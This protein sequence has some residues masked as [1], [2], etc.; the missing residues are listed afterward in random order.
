MPVALANFVHFISLLRL[1]VLRNHTAE[2]TEPERTAELHIFLIGH[3]VDNG[4]TILDKLGGMRAFQPEYMAGK[5]D[6]GNL[7]SKANTEIGNALGARIFR[8]KHHPLNA[9]LTEAARNDNRLR[10]L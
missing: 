2:R 1:A 8:S 5:F 6:N 3:Q 9:A 7:H 10:I 4:F